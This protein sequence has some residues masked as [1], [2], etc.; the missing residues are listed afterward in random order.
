MPPTADDVPGRA[1]AIAAEALFL[2]NLMLAPGIAFAALVWMRSHYI[3]APKLARCHIDQAFFA[4]I[5]SGM[6]LL[7]ATSILLLSGGIA[8]EWTWVMVILYFTCIH[9]TLILLGI[10]ALAKAQAGQL[11]VYPLIGPRHE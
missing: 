11:F 3:G 9:S 6:L 8:W 5:W 1:L 2:A 4:S 10:L 7:A